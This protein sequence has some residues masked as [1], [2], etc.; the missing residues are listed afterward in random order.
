MRSYIIKSI[1]WT[2]LFLILTALATGQGRFSSGPAGPAKPSAAQLIFADKSFFVRDLTPNDDPADPGYLPASAS[3]VITGPSFEGSGIAPWF[4]YGAASFSHED[5]PASAFDGDRF[6]KVNYASGQMSGVAQEIDMALHGLAPG[7]RVIVSAAVRISTGFY[8]YRWQGGEVTVE[9]V[10]KDGL[11]Q[12]IDSSAILALG[13]YRGWTELANLYTA[14]ADSAFIE[15]RLIVDDI[16]SFDGLGP[17]S[18]DYFA[19]F[20]A[21]C[22]YEEV[23]P[24]WLERIGRT[25][26]ASTDYEVAVTLESIADGVRIQGVLK[27]KSTLRRALDFGFSAL[28][29]ESAAPTWHHGFLSRQKAEPDTGLYVDAEPIDP[30]SNWPV[31]SHYP[32]SALEEADGTVHSLGMR[33]DQP[34]V[35]RILYDS[36]GRYDAR[37]RHIMEFP[38]GLLASGETGYV[39]FGF[40]IDSV[41]LAVDPGMNRGFRAAAESYLDRYASLIEPPSQI[42][43]GA[44]GS[45][46]ESEWWN[47]WHDHH[48]KMGVRVFQTGNKLHVETYGDD[49]Q[50]LFYTNPWR[51]G[52]PFSYPGVPEI[53]CLD[54]TDELGSSDVAIMEF[55]DAWLDFRYDDP[56]N[57]GDNVMHGKNNSAMC[58]QGVRNEPGLESRLLTEDIRPADGVDHLHL[59]VNLNPAVPVPTAGYWELNAAIAYTELVDERYESPDDHDYAGQSADL[60]MKHNRHLDFKEENIA[61]ANPYGLVYSLGALAPA[62]WGGLSNVLYLS[63][64]RQHLIDNWTMPDPVGQ[65][66]S[67]NVTIDFGHTAMA[68]PYLD[69]AGFE[70]SVL[71]NPL[72]DFNAAPEQQAFRRFVMNQRSMTRVY[73]PIDPG[74]VY[75]GRPITDFFKNDEDNIKQVFEELSSIAVFYGFYPGFYKTYYSLGYIDE[76]LAGILADVVNP[77]VVILDELT[78][79]GWEPATE[80]FSS[81]E[82]VWIERYGPADAGSEVHFTVLNNPNHTTENEE[83][84]LFDLT[85]PVDDEDLTVT[86]DSVHALGVVCNPFLRIRVSNSVSGFDLDDLF[87][88]DFV[89]GFCGFSAQRTGSLG[90]TLS[91]VAASGGDFTIDAR[92]L[93]TFTLDGSLTVDNDRTAPGSSRDDTPYFEFTGNM[94]SDL[95]ASGEE[96]DAIVSAGIPVIEPTA[97]CYW[98]LSEPGNYEVEVIWPDLKTD[99]AEAK[100]EVYLDGVLQ[101]STVLDQNSNPGTWQNLGLTV[102]VTGQGTVDKTIELVLSYSDLTYTG[103]LVADAARLKK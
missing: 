61:C 4:G 88:P 72:K 16:P 79:A 54:Y 101:G 60:Y 73:C 63:H 80:A 99:M 83:S 31:H 7:D 6:L 56:S 20:D 87:Y 37:R 48:E 86:I 13:P 35:C 43:A 33:L 39:D 5:D 97:T 1:V 91:I 41:R 38:V 27:N 78:A 55:H 58:A 24:T 12:V 96:G 100:Y 34:R 26:W 76:T 40:S 42:E 69:L 53:T 46:P 57:V 84:W 23:A 2:S 44:V 51:L 98:R 62:A 3:N 49:Y 92:D 45:T 15:V 9:V 70:S 93:Y 77:F 47:L 11:G 82:N 81:N 102:N 10:W 74:L 90:D 36:D 29:L 22:V 19:E 32:F 52:F 66:M 18:G 64:M 65:A 68:M 89:N 95:L 75:E 71:S 50:I 94:W 85:T 14:P 17:M 28:P 25:K 59:A 67:A 103:S 30:F 8:A 21:V